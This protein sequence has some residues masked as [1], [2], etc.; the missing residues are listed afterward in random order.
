M[1]TFNLCQLLSQKFLPVILINI[2]AASVPFAAL[3]QTGSAS[4]NHI[5][6]KEKSSDKE[7][8]VTIEG[9][10]RGGAF[11][12]KEDF[13]RFGRYWPMTPMKVNGKEW[14][15]PTDPFQLDFTPDFS[16][17]VLLEKE[18]AFNFQF[19][20]KE[21]SFSLRLV[22][23]DGNLISEIPFRVKFA[24]KNQIP[25]ENISPEDSG[26]HS[27]EQVKTPPVQT[28]YNMSITSPLYSFY[29]WNQIPPTINGESEMMWNKAHANNIV[30]IEG[31]F[32]GKGAIVITGNKYE[33]Q[34]EEFDYPSDVTINGRP[35][36]DLKEPFYTSHPVSSR[37]EIK[38][39]NFK[40]RKPIKLEHPERKT[41]IVRFDDHEA[42]PG[43]YSI[44][45]SPQLDTPRPDVFV[46]RPGAQFGF[47]PI[48][49]P[50]PSESSAQTAVAGKDEVRKN[51][52]ADMESRFPAEPFTVPDDADEATKTW[53]RAWKRNQLVLDGTFN[54]KGVFT[55]NL[56]KIEYR[57]EAF[58]PPVNVTINGKPWED[59]S[60]PF[61]ILQPIY[62]HNIYTL[63]K[64][65]SGRKNA[66]LAITGWKSFELRF[67]DHEDTPA[68]YHL[69]VGS[70]R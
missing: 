35:W 29:T 66:T 49:A 7:I 58:D 5:M 4:A 47:P 17:A 46:M 9:N 18:G 8:T 68:V 14:S 44:A 34:H 42:S 56:N 65:F 20:V 51:G 40:G 2:F 27:P 70:E 55:V 23:I 33:Y 69:T 25:R 50:M 13:I 52:K 22:P 1:R 36:K 59:L 37:P 6:D 32:N 21:D 62:N 54:G 60:Q 43:F 48:A 10:L 30:A 24:V 41:V 26:R 28:G 19:T 67:D 16:K 45:I 11:Q 39:Y 61:Y 15:R 31:N 12:F 53:S 63:V 38:D 64:E 57:H 3:A